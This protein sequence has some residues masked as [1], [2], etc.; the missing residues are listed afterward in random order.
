MPHRLALAAAI[1]LT[2]TNLAHAG[3]PLATEDAG[4]LVK[5]ECEWESLAARTRGSAAS[6][7]AWA[8]QWACGFMPEAQVALGYG[9]ARSSGNGSGS[10][11]HALSVNGKW[12]LLRGKDDE[13]SVVLAWGVVAGKPSGSNFK[14]GSLFLNGVLTKPLAQNWTGHLNLGWVQDRTTLPHRHAV[15]WN[16]A[17]EY[18]VGN[19]FEVMAEW[20]GVER[21]DAFVAAGLRWSASPAWSL[22]AGY[23]IQPSGSRAKLLSVGAKLTF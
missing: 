18:A 21:N 17:A 11:A 19:G 13:A 2:T 12:G 22:N 1:F 4:V 20:Y 7:H 16:M 9:H 8:T 3:R 6:T 15:T 14:L 5:G 10:A 23:A